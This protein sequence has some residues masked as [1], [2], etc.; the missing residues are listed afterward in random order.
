MY[1]MQH[2]QL[3][4]IH[5]CKSLMIMSILAISL[6]QSAHAYTFGLL[7]HDDTP[8]SI[9]AIE[10]KYDITLPMVSFIRDGYDTYIQQTIDQLPQTL[11]TNRVYHIT[12]SPAASHSQPYT[13]QQVAQ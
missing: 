5:L 6:Q 12:L 8:E 10:T 2:Y 13:S 3:L 7:A 4:L 11:G 1:L 9:Q